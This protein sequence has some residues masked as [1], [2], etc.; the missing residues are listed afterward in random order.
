MKTARLDRSCGKNKIT[1]DREYLRKP[2]PLIHG[3]RRAKETHRWAQETQTFDSWMEKSKGNPPLR[4]G[5]PNLW[6]WMKK[7]PGTQPVDL[8]KLLLE[9]FNYL[10]F[11]WCVTATKQIKQSLNVKFKLNHSFFNIPPKFLPR[12]ELSL[13]HK[14]KCSNPYIFATWWCKFLLFQPYVIWFNRIHIL[15][16]LRSKTFGL[17][18][19]VCGKDSIPFF[20]KFF[21][22][23]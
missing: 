20:A 15:K 17:Q 5:N 10:F 13:C 6:L 7:I 2:K 4:T 9:I 3:W 22:E 8:R 14:I 16:Y 1:L 18:T 21:G 11:Y 12:K 19:R 23:Y